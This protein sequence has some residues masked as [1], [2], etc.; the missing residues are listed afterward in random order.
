MT[1]ARAGGGG[2]KAG[3]QVRRCCLGPTERPVTSGERSRRGG[4]IRGEDRRDSGCVN[5]GVS[6]HYHP[7]GSAR[8]SW[9]F[10]WGRGGPRPAETGPNHRGKVAF[11]V[12]FALFV[13]SERQE[14]RF[15][16][17]C[18]LIRFCFHLSDIEFDV[19]VGENSLSKRW[20]LNWVR[21]EV[22]S[23]TVEMN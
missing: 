6:R 11:H 12:A 18:S 13:L 10:A 23:P 14:G 22:L 2:Q 3:V 21:I 16:R 19:F 9:E 17:K 5:S 15:G 20:G 8:A 4:T 7:W 1:F